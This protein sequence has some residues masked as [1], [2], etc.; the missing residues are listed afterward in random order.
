MRLLSEWKAVSYTYCE[1]VSVALGIPHELC[2]HHIAILGLPAIEYFPHYLTHGSN[3]EKIT[4]Q[5]MRVLIFSTNLI[6][7]VSLSK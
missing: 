5:K 4:A 7:N 1:C 3:F 6:Q 2:M